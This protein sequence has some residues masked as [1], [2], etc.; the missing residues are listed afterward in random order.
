ML[1]E[2]PSFTWLHP[3]IS[4]IRM[5]QYI[6]PVLFAASPDF[7]QKGSI[8]YDIANIFSVTFNFCPPSSALSASRYL[9]YIEFGIMGVFISGMI[10]LAKIYKWRGALPQWTKVSIIF[11]NFSFGYVLHPMFAQIIGIIIGHVFYETDIA[12]L[13][14]RLL[15]L[16]LLFLGLLSY[17]WLIRNIFLQ[18]STL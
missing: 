7:Y 9:A 10:I 1:D 4:V 5:L 18:C 16:F 17:Q 8:A 2:S 6:G 14:T 15:Q 11:F 13:W 3:I 12:P